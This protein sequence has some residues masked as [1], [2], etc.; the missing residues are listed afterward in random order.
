MARNLFYFPFALLVALLVTLGKGQDE[1][2]Y[3]FDFPE[4]TASTSFPE[5]NDFDTL[6]VKYTTRIHGPSMSLAL[7]C[8]VRSP[9]QVA[10]NELPDDND[11][12]TVGSRDDTPGVPG[13]IPSHSGT[14]PFKLPSL[15]QM[16][17]GVGG[18][19]VCTFILSGFNQEGT[20]IHL[21]SGM[22]HLLFRRD[23]GRIFKTYGVDGEVPDGDYPVLSGTGTYESYPPPKASSTALVPT[24]FSTSATTASSLTTTSPTEVDPLSTAATSGTSTSPTTST[25]ATDSANEDPSQ[26]T[27]ATEEENN[28][29]GGGGGGLSSTAS[30]GIGAGVAVGAIAILGLG[31]FLWWRRRKQR[32]QKAMGSGSVGE[33]G[34]APPEK[35]DGREVTVAELQGKHM[36][37]L[38][39]TDNYVG[40]P[41]KLQELGAGVERAEVEAREVGQRERFELP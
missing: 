15:P 27:G 5:Y 33:G 7:K 23:R 19:N 2:I 22:F 30:A 18:D 29:G 11:W 40:N 37:E 39:A 26:P 3:R 9:S 4:L 24:T 21:K 32:Q 10:N 16:Q 13:S 35:S 17:G 6:L 8:V 12:L 31:F 41:P 28:K 1:A 25:T 38:G 34:T 36:S 14:V 20:V